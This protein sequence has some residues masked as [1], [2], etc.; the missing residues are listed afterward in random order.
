MV[1]LEGEAVSYEPGAPVRLLYACGTLRAT[2]SS[3]VAL[4]GHVPRS[5]LGALLLAGGGAWLARSAW[6]RRIA[7]AEHALQALHLGGVD[8]RGLVLERGLGV[9]DSRGG[10]G[11]LLRLLRLLLLLLRRGHLAHLLLQ[12]LRLRIVVGG[13][14]PG[15]VQVLDLGSLLS[16]RALVERLEEVVVRRH[17]LHIDEFG[18]PLLDPIHLLGD[19]RLLVPVGPLPLPHRVRQE[20]AEAARQ[21][22]VL[23]HLLSEL[24]R[25]HPR[26]VR[27]FGHNLRDLDLLVQIILIHGRPPRGTRTLHPHERQ[28]QRHRRG[29]QHLFRPRHLAP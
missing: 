28:A 27:L 5:S 9:L 29:C 8:L 2:S 19:A 14:F 7:A 21:H 10:V 18:L 23:D 20:P 11:L 26:V 24:E 22:P 17:I 4:Q 1:V 13:D 15:P 6:A 12:D 25:A 16:R 3:Q